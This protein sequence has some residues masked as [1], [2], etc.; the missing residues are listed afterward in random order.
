[1]CSEDD[2]KGK[3]KIKRAFG[4]KDRGNPVGED[5]SCVA[6]V[7]FRGHLGEFDGLESGAPGRGRF[8]WRLLSFSSKSP[9]QP[10]NTLPY[11]QSP[12]IYP[13]CDLNYS[14]VSGDMIA[15]QAPHKSG[16]KHGVRVTAPTSPLLSPLT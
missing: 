9:D 8:V 14:F 3:G 16:R 2:N 6:H 5:C 13:S 11:L 12:A 4:P 1:V 7:R 15:Q 10:I